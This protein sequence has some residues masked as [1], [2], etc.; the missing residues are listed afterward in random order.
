M[1]ISSIDADTILG[2]SPHEQPQPGFRSIDCRDDPMLWLIWQKPCPALIVS[3]PSAVFFIA[4]PETAHQ[5]LPLQ[6]LLV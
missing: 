3:L 2:L 5:L 6:D 1:C 4:L